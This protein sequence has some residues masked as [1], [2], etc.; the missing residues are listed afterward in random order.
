MGGIAIKEKAFGT[1]NT[2]LGEVQVLDMSHRIFASGVFTTAGGDTAESIPV[3]GCLATDLAFVSVKS[4]T[5]YVAQALAGVGAIAVTMSENPGAATI[6]SY[7]I[8]RAL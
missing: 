7:M 2:A 6:L 8:L 4:G 3:S 1:I 5:G